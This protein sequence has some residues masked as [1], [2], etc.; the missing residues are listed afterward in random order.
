M[1]PHSMNLVIC[2][3]LSIVVETTSDR[4]GSAQSNRATGIFVQNT[5]RDIGNGERSKTL[6]TCLSS[7]FQVLAAA[8]MAP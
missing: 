8:D 1:S 3:E 4:R 2:P 7:A 6:H 5:I